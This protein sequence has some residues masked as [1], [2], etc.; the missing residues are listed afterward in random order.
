MLQTFPRVRPTTVCPSI[1]C[2]SNATGPSAQA[3]TTTLMP[4]SCIL[5]KLSPLVRP[6][7][8]SQERGAGLRAWS[9]VAGLPPTPP[10]LFL[11]YRG[12]K[13]NVHALVLLIRDVLFDV[14]AFIGLEMPISHSSANL[15]SEN[16]HIVTHLPKNQVWGGKKT[17]KH[18]QNWHRVP[19]MFGQEKKFSSQ[20]IYPVK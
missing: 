5:F 11:I 2:Y 3:W 19:T 4:C 17:P 12:E 6:S 13:K 20:E 8:Q 16:T 7:S 1:Q 10:S 9:S 14:V 15:W 18:D